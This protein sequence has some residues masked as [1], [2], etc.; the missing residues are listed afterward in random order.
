MSA[1]KSEVMAYLSEH[2]YGNPRVFVK[3]Y[4][5]WYN[6]SSFRPHK[7]VI[8][9]TNI[10][11][12]RLI[13]LYIDE[14]IAKQAN[15]S[16]LISITNKK[17]KERRDNVTNVLIN[18]IQLPSDLCKLVADYEWGKLPTKR[19]SITVRNRHLLKY[20]WVIC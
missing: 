3:L 17:K 11:R 5:M 12:I 13:Q 6:R 8:K 1:S 16:V 9:K 10:D 15:I 18:N 20:R 7:L 19:S 2:C 14:V 4:H